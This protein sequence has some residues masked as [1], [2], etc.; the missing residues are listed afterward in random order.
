[1]FERFT[2][3]ARDAVKRA[4]EESRRLG[5]RHIGTVHLLLAVRAGT[6]AGANALSRHGLELDDLRERVRRLAGTGEDPIDGAALA[7]I[8]I[9]LD[10]VRRAVEAEFG[11]GAL[12]S[13]RPRRGHI[14]FTPQSKKALELSLRSALALKHKHISSG[15]ILLGLLRATGD[16]LS[17]EL[18]AEA[19][20][21][22]EELRTTTTKLIQATAA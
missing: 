20:V 15:H 13:G 9:D 1:M 18:L 11:E 2:D 16:N 3:D 22:P 5:H 7:T 4:Q 8:G 17:L 12:E 19:G 6:G 10:E 21:D 14:P